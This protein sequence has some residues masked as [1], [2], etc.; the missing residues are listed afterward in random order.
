MLFN[1]I[2]WEREITNNESNFANMC[3]NDGDNKHKNDFEPHVIIDA[4]LRN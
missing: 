1:G 4:K 3:I 2:K